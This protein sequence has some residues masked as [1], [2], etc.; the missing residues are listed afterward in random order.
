MGRVFSD[1]DNRIFNKLAPEAGGSTDSGAG[2]LF[3]FILR[4]ISHRFAESGED[5]R[6]RLSLLDTEEIDYLA[7]LVLQNLEEITSLDEEDMESFLELVEERISFDKKR[8]ITH[9][10]GIVG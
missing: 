8:A 6:A 5:F 4:P 7:D 9:H 3:P 1:M 2:H 10:L